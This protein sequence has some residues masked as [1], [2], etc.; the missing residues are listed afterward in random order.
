MNMVVVSDSSATCAGF[1]LVG[2]ECHQAENS[3]EL[4]VA[5]DIVSQLEVGLIV[6]TAKLAAKGR[7]VLTRFSAEDMP[8][9]VEIPD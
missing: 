4:A 3:E 1:R 2:V 7:E 8:L 9:V 5:L 6:V